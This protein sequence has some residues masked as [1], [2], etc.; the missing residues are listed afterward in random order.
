MLP[1]RMASTASTSSRSPSRAAP[2]KAPRAAKTA[3][4]RA[5]A[6]TD[7]PLARYR[8]KRDFSI[9]SEPGPTA[10]ASKKALSF[11]IQ[12]HDATRLHYDFRL[13][14]NGGLLSWAVP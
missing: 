8:A 1:G 9:T 13:E 5:S 3:R 2:A 6:S 10:G 4:A 7:V 14:L 12:K 11:V